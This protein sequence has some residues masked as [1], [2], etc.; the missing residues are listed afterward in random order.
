MIQY[1]EL[2]KKICIECPK[3]YYENFLFALDG[4]WSI[5]PNG[6]D[7]Y[8]VPKQKETHVAH[9]V[10]WINATYKPPVST[11]TNDQNK[12]SKSQDPQ[13]YYKTFDMKPVDFDKIYKIKRHDIVD[14]ELASDDDEHTYCSSSS[15]NH[16]SSSSYGTGSSSS[17]DNFPSPSTPKKRHAS[18]DD[19]EMLKTA[20]N[21]LNTRVKIIEQKLGI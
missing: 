17:S 4:I 6:K 16:Y 3:E 10:N 19:T 15:G 11:H 20:L 12:Y 5:L 13:I 18:R 8:L 21:K 14:D 9:I 2:N 7:I 1:Y